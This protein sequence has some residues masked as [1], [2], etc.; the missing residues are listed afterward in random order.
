MAIAGAVLVGAYSFA[1]GAL[2]LLMAAITGEGLAMV[3]V[4]VVNAKAAIF[5]LL[6]PASFVIVHFVRLLDGGRGRLK[7]AAKLVAVA[8]LGLAFCGLGAAVVFDTWGGPSRRPNRFG[9]YTN[10]PPNQDEWSREWNPHVAP[11]HVVTNA[12]GYRD[13]PWELEADSPRALLVGDSFVWGVGIVEKPGMLD[14]WIEQVLNQGCEAGSCWQVL[15]IGQKP[16]GLP[17]YLGSL[18]AV[19]KEARP[20]VM[21]MSY[22]GWLDDILLDMPTL[23][24]GQ[25]PLLVALLDR[26]DVTFDLMWSNV[27]GRRELQRR[28]L[29]EIELERLRARFGRFVAFLEEQGTPLVVW[30]HQREREPIFEPYRDHPLLTFL[31]WSM[32]RPGASADYADASSWQ[33]TEGYFVPGDGHPTALANAEF[34]KLIARAIRTAVSKQAAAPAAGPKPDPMKAASSSTKP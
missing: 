31:D 20:D 13:E 26:L 15:N 16:A 6:V 4:A 2:K 27:A 9:Y 28:L 24:H 3:Y 19:G 8:T 30:V 7:R 33:R 25:P 32:V 1:N 23:L 29:G 5:L 18:V 14:S 21:I 11:M 34:A 10:N 22:L 17:Y 12:L